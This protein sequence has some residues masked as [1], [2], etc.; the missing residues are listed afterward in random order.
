MIFRNARHTNQLELLV[1]FYT[2]INGLEVLG[3]FEN[4]SGYDG[5]FLGYPS[6]DWHLEFTQSTEQV[7]HAFDEDDCLVFYPTTTSAFNAIFST[8]K[9]K[10]ITPIKAKNPYWNENGICILDPDGYTVI[11]SPLKT[12]ATTN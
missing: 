6:A 11:I 8:I 9:E 10:Q 12:T 3:R 2:Q 7:K 4:H 1:E 5:V